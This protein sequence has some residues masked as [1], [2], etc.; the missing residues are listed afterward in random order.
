MMLAHKY[1]LLLLSAMPYSVIFAFVYFLVSVLVTVL[2]S[3]YS[4]S[5]VLVFE[6][7]L[8]YKKVNW[9]LFVLVFK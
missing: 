1:R 2:E 5:Q 4:F 3:V 8:Y 9:R 6:D 7:A